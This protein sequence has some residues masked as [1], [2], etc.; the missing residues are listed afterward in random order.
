MNKKRMMKKLHFFQK[1]TFSYNSILVVIKGL[2]VHKNKNS[3][4]HRVKIEKRKLE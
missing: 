4:L 3:L 1:V 2:K